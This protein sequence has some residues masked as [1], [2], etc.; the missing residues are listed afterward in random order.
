MISTSRRKVGALILLLL[1]FCL[2]ADAK[3]PLFSEPR[4]WTSTWAFDYLHDRRLPLADDQYEYAP[5]RECNDLEWLD[6]RDRSRWIKLQRLWWSSALDDETIRIAEN[7]ERRLT[8]QAFRL[9]LRCSRTP[10]C[11]LKGKATVLTPP[12]RPGS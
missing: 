8:G 1:S 2:I 10:R 5:S 9:S 3:G 6:E 7:I 4:R 11:A 12:C